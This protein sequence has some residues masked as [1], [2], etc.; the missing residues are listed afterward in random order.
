MEELIK[1]KGKKILLILFWFIF[2]FMYLIS[3][4][5]VILG[6]IKLYLQSPNKCSESKN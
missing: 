5:Q 2:N 4:S 1:V 6:S 3:I